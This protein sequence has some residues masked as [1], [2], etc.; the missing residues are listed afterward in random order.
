MLRLALTPRWL[1]LLA[2]V[3]VLATAFVG[4]SAWQV[5]RAQHKNDAIAAQDVDTPRPFA[6]VM[7]AQVPMPSLLS[8]QMVDL[9]G[10]YLPD[11]QVVIPGRLQ[12]GE[13]GYW[14]V[15]MFAPD[16]APLGPAVGDHPAAES[17][18]EVP[19]REVAIAVVRGWTADEETAMSSR[20]DT[21]EVT[22]RARVG[23]NEAPASTEDLP[24]G[25]LRTVATAQLVNMFDVYT[26]AGYLFPEYD[27]GPG[28]SEAVDGLEH[29]GLEKQTTG[30]F[31]LQ[32]AAYAVEWLFFAGFALY[33]WFSLLRDAH[34]RRTQAAE[35][36]GHGAGGPVEYVVV[37]PAGTR[38][39]TTAG[40]TTAGTRTKGGR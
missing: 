12:D 3:L 20:A 26:Y 29:V 32:S 25:Q 2:L 5:D 23:V 37:K 18:P 15:T 22:M 13:E 34:Q 14:V 38:E 19:D 30:G 24:E 7:D 6:E 8:D 36:S 39:L 27:S 16:D 40:R 17:E 11:M 35:A 10:H 31:D 9:T 21:G 33:I 1:A 4:L 28:A